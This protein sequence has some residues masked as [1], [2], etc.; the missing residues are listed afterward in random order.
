MLVS[1]PDHPGTEDTRRA[2][3]DFV[4]SGSLLYPNAPGE[5]FV[6]EDQPV[7]CLVATVNTAL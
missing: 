7:N 4:W 2:A 6:E 5:M 3:S 1:E